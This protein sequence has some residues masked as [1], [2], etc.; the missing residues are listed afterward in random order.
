MKMSPECPDIVR[1]SERYFCCML[2]AERSGQD[3]E[4]C[5]I[6]PG[7]R[8]KSRE[9]PGVKKALAFAAEAHRGQTRK[10]TD[11]PYLIH[12]IRTWDYVNR[13]TEEED[14]LVAALL[15]DVLEDTPVMFGEIQEL[16]GESVAELVAGE[17]E[18]KREEYPA[19]QTWRIRKQET[20]H[21][22]QGCLGIEKKRPA[23]HIAFGDKLANLFSMAY[24]YHRAGES[25]WNKFNQTDKSLHAWYYGEMGIIF[26]TY[27]AW[28][29][30]H[31]LVE[32]YQTYYKE[33][34][35]RYEISVGR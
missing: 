9:L 25:L 20:I 31:V 1:P 19:S 16:F 15:H 29:R 22:L 33:V 4:I 5:S 17:S 11:I 8:D 13:M 30:E 24:E 7:L 18:Y 10:G 35:G 6:C 32:E 23:M 12:L 28:G 34:F 27:F 26:D 21:R 3:E 2:K 14:E